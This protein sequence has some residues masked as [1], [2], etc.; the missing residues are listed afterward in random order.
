MTKTLH[1][2]L[3]TPERVLQEEDGVTQVTVATEQGEVTILPGHV[4]FVAQ[5]KPGR[6]LVRKGD[7]EELLAISTG[8][9]AVDGGLRVRILA[10]TADRASDLD[11]RAIQ[12]A[13]EEA[14]RVMNEK[15][16]VDDE[17]FAR[18]AAALERE[19]AKERVLRNRAYKD[20]MR[21]K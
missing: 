5:L 20:P 19:L 10:D 1:L 12:K 21:R 18:A 11:E 8:L 14:Q 4:D 2:S 6:V 9:L 7:V 15:R 3:I 13:K 17:A 16:L